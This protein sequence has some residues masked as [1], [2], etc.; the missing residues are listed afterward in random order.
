MCSAEE[1]GIIAQNVDQRLG[2]GCARRTS[3]T[4]GGINWL[5]IRF[6]RS[7]IKG[8]QRLMILKRAKLLVEI[9]L[10]GYI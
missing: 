4:F 2:G 1:E 7:R 3:S 10:H 9:T 8:L 5:K 6:W